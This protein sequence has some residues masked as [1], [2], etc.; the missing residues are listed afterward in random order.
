MAEVLSG[1]RGMRNL[2]DSLARLA[3]CFVDGAGR[4]LVVCLIVAE[5][6]I[7]PRRVHRW[8]VVLDRGIS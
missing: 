6:S 8:I 2:A 5:P 1:C 7:P 4:K 3:A